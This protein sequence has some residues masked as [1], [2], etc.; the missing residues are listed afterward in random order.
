MSSRLAPYFEWNFDLNIAAGCRSVHGGCDGFEV[1]ANPRPFR[2]TRQN[3]DRDVAFLEILLVA[4]PA[5][6]REQKLHPVVLS[7]F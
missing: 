5:V 2:R 6:R 7:G 4:H 3:D 1:K